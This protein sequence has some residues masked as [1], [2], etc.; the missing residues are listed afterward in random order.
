MSF[1][2]ACRIA[3]GTI[4]LNVIIES[5]FTATGPSWMYDEHLTNMGIYNTNL[6]KRTHCSMLT[7][8]NEKQPCPHVLPNSPRA[9]PIPYKSHGPPRSTTSRQNSQETVL[10]HQFL[11]PHS[12]RL[13]LTPPQCSH[14][15]VHWGLQGLS[16]VSSGLEVRTW[17][18]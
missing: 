9:L 10:C 2:T 15:S 12:L 11:S 3:V 17:W 4:D 1:V 14:C 8:Q 5:Y 13:E 18:F 7:L 6:R 16:D